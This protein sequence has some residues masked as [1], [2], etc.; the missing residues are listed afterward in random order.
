M[1]EIYL[2]Q[3]NREPLCSLPSSGA[4]FFTWLLRP[5]FLP[6]SLQPVMQVREIKSL[7]G[8]D[9][10]CATGQIFRWN[11]GPSVV[12]MWW[13]ILLLT[14]RQRWRTDP[15]PCRGCCLLR[16]AGR[17]GRWGWRL[18][19][20]CGRV[21]FFFFSEINIP[22]V[23]FCCSL[24]SCPEASQYGLVCTHSVKLPYCPNPTVYIHAACG[25]GCCS[26]SGNS[27]GHC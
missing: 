2:C 11:M 12:K 5:G 27:L 10:M 15:L 21:A 25:G 16:G 3:T 9:L 4:T 20:P 13:L 17:W 24:N 19:H 22:D 26:V 1:P 8:N 7:A 6:V 23:F 14:V 18:Q